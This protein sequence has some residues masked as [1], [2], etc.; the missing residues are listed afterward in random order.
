MFFNP[1]M[2]DGVFKLILLQ[3]PLAGLRI[4][5]TT[6]LPEHSR[7]PYFFLEFIDPVNLFDLL[8]VAHLLFFH[9]FL[10]VPV[11]TLSWQ[12]YCR[13]FFFFFQLLH[14]SLK[15]FRIFLDASLT[16]LAFFLEFF[17]TLSWQSYCRFFLL[18][19]QLLHSSPKILDLLS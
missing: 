19:F 4:F 18:V 9:M 16:E 3:Q 2:V 11:L 6:S 5:F 17:L 7:K 12:F 14:S 8:L 1:Y 15:I 13:F 10:F